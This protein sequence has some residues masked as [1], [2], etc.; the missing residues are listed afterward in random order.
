MPLPGGASDKFGNRYEG[1]WTVSCMV[2]VMDE[3]ADAIR[4]E[5]PGEEGEGAE[6]WLERDEKREYHQVKRQYVSEGRW[7]LTSLA[8]KKILLRFWEKL[9]NDGA[10]CVFV[11]TH[12]AY[13]LDEL[14]DRAKQSASWD[15]FNREFLTAQ[16]QSTN[17]YKL[18][19]YWNCE[20]TDAY[21]ALRRID[22]ETISERLL[23]TTVESHLATLV[24]GDP[25]TILDILAQ[26]ALD[27]VHCKLIAQDIWHH[28]E[29]RGYPRRQWGKD[30]HILAAVD[31]IN[32]RYIGQLQRDAIG[33]QIIPRDE[34]PTAL[35]FLTSSDGKRGVLISGEAGVGKSNVLFQV[36]EA[37]I[38]QGW[39]TL[40]FRVD[41]L[42]PTL[43]P[44]EIG[45]Q[46]G[47]PD[48]PTNV[49]ANIAQGQQCL[50]VIDQLD[51][52]SLVSGRN[53]DFFNCVDEIIRQ[54]QVH[55][56]MHLLLACRKF[57]LDNDHRLRRLTG[58]N[59]VADDVIV[60]PLSHTIVKQVV[61]KMGLEADRLHNTQLDLLSIPLHLSL[62]AEIIDSHTTNAFNFKTVKD[63]YDQFWE[64]KQ[65]LVRTRLNRS[66][67]WTKVIDTL[68]DYMNK[69]QGLSALKSIVDE[70]ADDAKAMVSEH[71]LT[72][73]GQMYAFFHE[74]FFDYA[75][76]RRFRARG[77]DLLSFLLSGEQHLFRRAQ[78][79]QILLHERDADRAIYLTDLKSLLTSADIRFHIKQVAMALLAKMSDPMEEEWEIVAL[80]MRD[81]NYQISREAWRVL[82]GS[83]HWFQLVQSLGLLEKWLADQDEGQVDRAVMFLWSVQKQ[84]QNQVAELVEPYIGVSDVWHNRLIYLVQWANLGATRRF[85]DLFL[86]LIDEGILDA[87][88]GSIAVNGDFW[89]LLHSLPQEHPDWTCEVIGHY[90]NRCLQL[91]LSIGQPNPF[92]YD[93]DTIPYSQGSYDIFVTSATSAPQKFVRYVLPFMLKVMGLTA[94]RE[95]NLPWPDQVW[96]HRRYGEG[97]DIK[98]TLL[99]AM[100][101]ALRTLASNEPESFEAIATSL[102]NSNF[103][104]A[105]YLLV[106]AYSANGV[107]FTHEA[108]TYLCDNPIRLQ[109]GYADSPYWATHQLLQAITP[110][111]SDE[112]MAQLENLILNYYHKWERSALGRGLFG[113]SQY[114]LLEGIDASRRTETVNRRLKE[115]RRKFGE[116][117]A[118]GPQSIGMAGIVGSPIPQ[119]SVEK[120]TDEQWLSAIMRY[121]SEDI[122]SER[123]GQLV[124]GAY[125]LSTLLEEHVKKDPLRFSALIHRFPDN[126]HPYYFNAVLRGIAD[127]GFDDVE[128]VLQVCQRCHQLPD[129]PCGR[130]ISEPIAKLAKLSLP[131]EA[132]DIVAWYATEDADPETEMWRTATGTGDVFYGGD[133]LTAGINSVQGRIAW[134]I[135]E[136]VFHDGSRIPDFQPTLERLVQDTSIAVRACVAKTLIA[137][138]RH[139]RDLAIRLFQQLCEAEDALL[140]TEDI[141]G[142]LRYALQTHF[143]ILKPILERMIISEIAEVAQAGARQ[144]CLASLI[145]EAAHSFVQRCLSGTEAHQT[146]AAKVFAVNL[147]TALFRKLCESSLLQL[148]NSPYD[149]ARS[150]AATCFNRFKGEE[151]GECVALIEAFTQSSA[152]STH[153]GHLIRAL[154][155]TTAKLP[156]VTCQVCE[157][158]LNQVILNPIND[159]AGYNFETDIVAQ[160][161]I[162]VY[163]QSTNEVLQTR[164]LDLIDQMMQVGVYGLH[165]ALTLYER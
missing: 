99:T 100:E 31:T 104:T 45:R 20:Q 95:G 34:V 71:V 69:R 16:Q 108:V 29:N 47:L 115:L 15:E 70:Y 62:L 65:T 91:S 64:R 109:T 23:R 63:L 112:Q 52:V 126:T 160:L 33:G 147:P 93:T 154:D 18:C 87:A 81:E 165:K 118:E 54:V 163:S 149:N 67:L 74:G 139:N 110:H 14:A 83:V 158:Y 135:G 79:R 106:R 26:F 132:L 164:C 124:G 123:D 125:E 43:L 77:Y 75:F 36:V 129:R 128:S 41:R 55:P 140:K 5:P 111:C 27:K 8:G 130:W 96:R 49:L 134:A 113:Y 37:L 98:H 107:R 148:F 73:D 120:M 35:Q 131:N 22:V 102:C 90:L 57:D 145:L 153:Y 162:R 86:R 68:C 146:G 66:S 24:E 50:L 150:E 25:A 53:P 141:E 97:Y 51:T 46:L 4:L 157:Y 105:Q 56:Q 161:L 114:V 103:E 101:I 117:S 143:E 156:D 48:S 85:F 127:I 72:L 59:G 159:R 80:L 78:V 151:L 40:V 13:E 92:D 137:M 28:L 10:Y 76:A 42:E 3:R 136:L 84:V 2:K 21:K 19:R 144:A 133:I 39:P 38:A 9:K 61:T 17:F 7:M 138:L 155:K 122:S 89:A 58:K 32:N 116:Q 1:L 11:S 6:F 94:K 30:P 60:K 44:D 121:D 142:F 12:A 119:D 82:D 88:K 152:F